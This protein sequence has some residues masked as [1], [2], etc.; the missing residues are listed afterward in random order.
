MISNLFSAM[1]HVLQTEIYI[2][3]GGVTGE[4]RTVLKPQQATG[5][6]ANDPEPPDLTPG[7]HN[8][9]LTSVERSGAK[10]SEKP[11]D[12]KT[13]LPTSMT[14][15]DFQNYNEDLLQCVL[16]TSTETGICFVYVC[17]RCVYHIGLT[18]VD[19]LS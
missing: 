13:A 10:S 17:S 8:G 12:S 9:S 16:E 5:S 6:A 18:E 2:Y 15:T 3:G 14:G 11:E 4:A 19:A 7:R 1:T